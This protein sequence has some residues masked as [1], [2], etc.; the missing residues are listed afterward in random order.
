MK[1]WRHL[2]TSYLC[3]YQLLPGTQILKMQLERDSQSRNPLCVQESLRITRDSSLPTQNL[4]VNRPTDH[5]HT[6]KVVS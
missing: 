3:R 5:T 4:G 2:H 6:N 1:Q